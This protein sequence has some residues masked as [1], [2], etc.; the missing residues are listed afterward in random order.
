MVFC[1]SNH[2]Q[3][4]VNVQQKAFIRKHTPRGAVF[5]TLRDICILH[6]ATRLGAF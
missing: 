5:T 6:D 2:L 4:S 3:V 1:H